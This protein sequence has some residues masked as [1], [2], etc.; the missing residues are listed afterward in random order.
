MIIYSQYY[1][2]SILCHECQLLFTANSPYDKKYDAPKTRD[3]PNAKIKKFSY[4]SPTETKKR[5][6]ELF[7]DTGKKE[8]NQYN[9]KINGSSAHK[10]L[11]F[12]FA[13]GQYLLAYFA[14]KMLFFYV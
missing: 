5:L 11:I 8:S 13:V 6:I 1:S 12:L 3:F 2:I 4:F 9:K 14:V 10:P 7:Y